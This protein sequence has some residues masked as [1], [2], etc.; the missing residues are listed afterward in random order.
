[1]EDLGVE[2]KFHKCESTKCSSVVVI[3]EK[4]GREILVHRFS[5][6]NRGNLIDQDS[7]EGE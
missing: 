2:V 1:M 7:G 6:D 3:F 5:F 4:D